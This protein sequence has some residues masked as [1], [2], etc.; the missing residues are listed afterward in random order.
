[1]KNVEVNNKQDLHLEQQDAAPILEDIE[2]DLL[3]EGIFRHYG[4]DFRQYARA[5][6][7]R[8][9]RNFMEL[10]NIEFVSDLQNKILHN[11][12]VMERFLLNLSVNVT[13]MFRDVG[14]YMTFREKIIPILHTYPSIRIWHA[15]CSTGEEVYSLA[16][17]LQEEQLADKA[18]IYATDINEAAIKKAKAGI[19]PLQVMQEYTTNYL[20]AGGKQEFSR[21]YTAK[22]EHAILSPELRSR[23]VFAKH[24]LVTDSSFNEFT[25]IFCRNVMIYF[26]E[27]LRSHVHQLLYNSL[28]RFGTLILGSQETIRFT[29]IH[30]QYKILDEQHSIFQK[31]I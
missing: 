28:C 24:N 18:T 30:L 26:N 7:A 22:Y 27:E 1:M 17:L 2:I 9:I 13:S 4:F 21:Y 23:V 10:E 29:P 6:L 15:G 5:S 31:R 20:K 19:F 8:R 3:C 11:R 25:V 14:M 12:Q 16:I